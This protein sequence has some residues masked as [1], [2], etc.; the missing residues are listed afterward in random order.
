M[1]LNAYL[2][3]LS[4]QITLIGIIIVLEIVFFGVWAVLY[5]RRQAL[6][7][8]RSAEIEE[9]RNSFLIRSRRDRL[10]NEIKIDNAIAWINTILGQLLDYP[11]KLIETPFVVKDMAVVVGLADNGKSV[12]ISTQRPQALERAFKRT[13][14]NGRGMD[15]TDIDAAFSIVKGAKAHRAALVDRD[16][17]DVFDLEVKKAGSLLGIDWGE[18]D[19]L[20]FYVGA[21]KGSNA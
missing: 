17:S 5:L 1:E 19:E 13:G 6:A 18:S 21:S 15:A 14:Q 4:D 7:L 2:Q 20:W 16:T 9:Q 10:A 11:I 3:Q 12:A 8:K